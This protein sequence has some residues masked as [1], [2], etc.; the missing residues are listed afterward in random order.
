MKLPMMIE[1]EIEYEGREK[2]FISDF[3]VDGDTEWEI[4]R[5]PFEYNDKA[6]EHILQC[7]CI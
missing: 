7:T 1:E 6:D 3:E 4:N 5:R 2:Y